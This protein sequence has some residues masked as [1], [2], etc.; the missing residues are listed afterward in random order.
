MR[1]SAR[2]MCV[3]VFCVLTIFFLTWPASVSAQ[4]AN[5]STTTTSSTDSV[6]N[7]LMPNV[8]SNVPQN[9]HEYT[10]IVVIDVLSAFMCQLTGI[11]PT[12]PGQPCLGVNPA[13]GKI[14]MI[15]SNTTQ[16]FGQAPQQPQVGG[17]VGIMTNY[18]SDLYVPAVSASQYTQ[19]LSDNFGIVK[20]SYAAN[21][22]TKNANCSNYQFGYGFCGLSPIFNLWVGVRDFAYAF[23]TLLFI[24]IGIGVMLRFHVDPRT[25]MTLQNQIPRV[26]I[27]I[28][29]ITFSY[30]IAGAMIDMM[31]TVTYAGIN[32][33]TSVSPNS[34]VAVG[35]GPTN[36]KSL[37][38]AA[39]QT[40]INQPVAFT[41]MV[42]NKDCK[43]NIHSGLF[44]LAQ[45]VSSAFGQLITQIINQILGLQ[46]G[47]CGIGSILNPLPCLQSF[48]EWILEQTVKLIIIIAILIAL[49][50]LW[51]QL[52]K[53]Y[54]T[55]IIFVIMGPLWIVFGL[56]P[57]RPL[58]FEKWIR[59]VFANLAVFP[60]VAFMIVFARVLLDI[61][62]QTVTPQNMFIPPFIGNPNIT[63]FT[64]FMGFGAIMILP[65]IPDMIKE[66]M[67]ATGQ[68]KYG[69]TVA[70]GLGFAAGAVSSPGKKMWEHVNRHNPSTGEP[71]GALA[72]WKQRQWERTPLG[73]KGAAKRKLIRDAYRE[74]KPMPTRWKIKQE[75]AKMKREQMDERN[76]ERNARTFERTARQQDQ[77]QSPSIARRAGRRIGRIFRRGQ[78]PGN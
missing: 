40:L 78:P 33:I 49:F 65:T 7:F 25:V 68:G 62:P 43:G 27:A 51:F 6:N 72:V 8:D 57:G 53:T 3:A 73:R 48:I 39:D 70:A 41:D 64:T 17:A 46:P 54:I 36:I 69:Q 50:R 45:H 12:N 60:L 44:N 77:E 9:H 19:Y 22:I 42:F 20:K 74:G 63:T 1:V 10:Q 5:Q 30:A 29:L 59:I 38:Q 34:Q 16:Q 11:D 37:P 13:T 26:I 67:K 66:R 15:P 2:I 52:I 31:W 56:I 35:C 18:I 61:A 23:L 76:A 71:E 58:G 55:F 4:T 32:F 21:A 47:G 28:L 24:A 75:T 14:G